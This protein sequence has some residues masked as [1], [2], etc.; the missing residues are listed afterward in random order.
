M[1]DEREKPR[2][3]SVF[4]PS[5][6]MRAAGD[7]ADAMEQHGLTPGQAEELAEKVQETIHA[8]MR[9]VRDKEAARG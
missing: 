9:R 1:A 2:R 5:D 8:F 3:L 6:L 7:A 4:Y